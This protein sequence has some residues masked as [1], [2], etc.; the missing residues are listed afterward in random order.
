MNKNNI[1]R[2]QWIKDSEMKELEE[3][4]EV[5]KGIKEAEEYGLESEVMM[6]FI[7]YIQQGHTVSDSINGALNEWIK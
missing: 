3:A 5:L 6:F 1:Q 7:R 4:S 2:S